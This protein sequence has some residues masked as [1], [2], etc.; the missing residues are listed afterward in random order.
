MIR[1]DQRLAS[2][3][4]V[5]IDFEATGSVPGFANEPWQIGMVQVIDGRVSPTERYESL[6]R[7]GDRPFNPHAPGNH[8]GLREAL[9]EAPT[10]PSLWGE[11]APWVSLPLV[12]HNAATERS[13][14][15]P[16]APLH[17]FGPWVDTLKLARLAYPNLS[18]YALQDLL[19]AVGLADAVRAAC[20]D[21]EAHDALYD[22]VASGLFLQHL[23]EQPGWCD[24][25]FDQLP[26]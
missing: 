23:L 13:L 9:R 6:L 24:L 1:L 16:V 18:S 4:L 11:I 10:L 8:H 19:D 2:A 17:R 7:I 5:A 14:L 26:P 12:A 22:A 20:P 3:T 15:R 21:R 25:R